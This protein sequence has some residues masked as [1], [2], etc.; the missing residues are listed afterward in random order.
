[1]LLSSESSSSNE[2]FSRKRTCTSDPDECQSVKKIK[3]NDNIDW[4]MTLDYWWHV[5]LFLS[6]RDFVALKA[7]CQNLQELVA[8]F[9]LLDLSKIKPKFVTDSFIEQLDLQ[10]W[11]CLRVLDLSHCS[12]LTDETVKKL[13]DCPRIKELYLSGCSKLSSTQISYLHSSNRFVY[14]HSR[15]FQWSLKGFTMD[16]ANTSIPSKVYSEPFR[17]GGHVWRGLVFPFGNHFPTRLP[18]TERWL[19]LYVENLT[20]KSNS[21]PPIKIFFNLTIINR[22]DSKSIT[23]GDLIEFGNWMNPVDRGF[24]RLI[25][26][27]AIRNDNG[28]TTCNCLSFKIDLHYS[29]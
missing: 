21:M 4:V 9:E 17:F 5:S 22:D 8:P 16:P 27:D 20:I 23:F 18:P 10:H 15:T 11:P 3:T 29:G 14:T 19:S 6:L 2:L 12:E 25:S 13:V 7:T 28:F 26:W 1:M 24:Q